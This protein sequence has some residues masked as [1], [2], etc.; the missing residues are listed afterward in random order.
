MDA[1]EDAEDEA[2][3]ETDDVCVVEGDVTSQLNVCAVTLSIMSLTV[4]AAA[5]HKASCLTMSVGKREIG[6][7][8]V[9]ETH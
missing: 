3:V 7:I 9:L 2:D 6:S 8:W 1:E 4:A 5:L